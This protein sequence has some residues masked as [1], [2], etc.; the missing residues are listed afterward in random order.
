ML[1]EK[2]DQI[3]PVVWVPSAYFAM[4]LPFVTIALVVGIMYKNMGISDAQI[5]VWTGLIALPWTLKPLWSPVLEMFKTKKYFVVISQFV[6]GITFALVALS[7]PLSGFFTY[8]IALLGIIAFSGATNDIATDGVYLD[9]LTPKLQAEYIGWQGAFYNIAKLLANGGFV[10][11][12]GLLEKNLGVLNA[13]IAVML[14]IGAVMILLAFYHV[15]MLP[16]GRAVTGEV[17]SLKD[18]FA[19]LWDV[20]LTFFKKKHIFWYIAFI[21]LYRFAEGFAVKIVPLF[22][23]AD[24]ADGGLGLTTAE[25]GVIIGTAGT[26]AFVLGSIGGGYFIA[27]RGLKRVRMTLAM[28]FNLPFIMYALLAFYRPENLFLVGGAVVIEYFGYGF[29]FVGLMLFMMQQIAPGKYK[30][31]HYAFATAIMNLGFMIPSMLSGVLSD[32]VGY[33]IFFMVVLAAT[34]PAFLATYFVPFG[35]LDNKEEKELEET[36]TN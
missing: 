13:W 20:L 28:A 1:K 32:A 27:S 26:A 21:I 10:L 29:G 5:T 8:S 25:I 17:K 16:K 2:T 11:L 19:T 35:H 14:A 30:M 6:T 33:K 34:I 3:H 9:V 36:S 15:R 22:F 12:A 23:L 7:L 31:A 18:G 4:G 24:V